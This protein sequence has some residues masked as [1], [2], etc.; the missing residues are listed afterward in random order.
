MT[1]HTEEVY[2][3][4]ENNPPKK[5]NGLIKTTWA[6]L[7]EAISPIQ[8]EWKPWLPKGL[9][10]MAASMSGEGKSALSLR[11]SACY[12]DGLPWP[13]QSPYTGGPGTVLWCEAESAQAVNL[14]RA[15]SWG[16]KV[17]RFLTPLDDG[18][19]DISLDSANH[20]KAIVQRASEPEVKLIVVDSLSGSSN[21]K[22]KDEEVGRVTHWLAK[23]ARDLNKPVLLTHHI[24]KAG[25]F[26]PKEI[27]LDRVRGSTTIVQFARVVWA[28]DTPDQSQP[29][30]KRLY[31]IKNNLSRF[32]DPIGMTITDKGIIFGEAPEPPKVET[33]T[34]KAEDLLL[35][36]L[37]KEPKDAEYIRGET[38]GAGISWNT[39]CI[40]KKNLG[41][42]SKKV[43]NKWKWGLPV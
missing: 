29:D 22:E 1:D 6:D 32:A 7:D 18:F 39:V 34:G 14:D 10:T 38:E 15:K 21:R 20:R 12:T 27:T 36:L 42:V 2:K 16:F 26:E 9:L 41:I 24:R 3:L 40:A 30:K 25:Q 33:Q 43:G 19:V 13:D 35:A 31:M 37:A 23:L 28:L 5:G 4:N 8:F 17:D 11:V